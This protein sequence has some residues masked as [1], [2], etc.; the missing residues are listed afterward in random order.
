MTHIYIHKISS[1]DVPNVVLLWVWMFNAFM[2]QFGSSQVLFQTFGNQSGSDEVVRA[3][4]NMRRKSRPEVKYGDPYDW[5]RWSSPWLIVISHVLGQVLRWWAEHVLLGQLVTLVSNSM[6]LVDKPA[7]LTIVPDCVLFV[8]SDKKTNSETV[9]L[10]SP[11]LPGSSII[12]WACH[13]SSRWPQ[14]SWVESA[15][16]LASYCVF[17]FCK[18]PSFFSSKLLQDIWRAWWLTY[19]YTTSQIL[20]LLRDFTICC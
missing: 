14:R 13:W 12:W 16:E 2:R 1:Q 20:I 8:K 10:S 7:R 17:F 5:V 9:T 11:W 6:S 19:L 15:F 18:C 4:L 3:Q